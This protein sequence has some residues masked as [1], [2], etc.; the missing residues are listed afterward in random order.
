MHVNTKSL[1]RTCKCFEKKTE[2]I[3]RILKEIR[4]TKYKTT[5][6]KDKGRALKER[7]KKDKYLPLRGIFKFN[8]SF[9]LNVYLIITQYYLFN[10]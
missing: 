4:T 5:K 6:D 8:N 1:P 2:K 3:K 10:N 9:L 7:L